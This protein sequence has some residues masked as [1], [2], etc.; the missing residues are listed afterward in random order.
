MTGAERQAAL[1]RRQRAA[2]LVAYGHPKGQPTPAVLAALAQQLA[3]LDDPDQ[4]NDHDTLRSMA[5]QVLH[6]LA[7]R[8]RIKISSR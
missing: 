5:A 2:T 6:E 8:Y 7:T 1:R 3:Q 4:V